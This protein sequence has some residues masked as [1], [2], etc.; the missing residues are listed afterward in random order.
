M[1]NGLFSSSHRHYRRKWVVPPRQLDSNVS[2]LK[3]T[4]DFTV[5]NLPKLSTT[6]NPETVRF[7]SSS[8]FPNLTNLCLY[9][10]ILLA[11]GLP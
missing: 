7:L 5:T 8:F 9:S 2:R 4:P 6:V 1:T 3:P 11:L 10:I